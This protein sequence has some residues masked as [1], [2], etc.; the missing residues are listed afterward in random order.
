MD[1]EQQ[2]APDGAMRRGRIGTLQWFDFGASYR[3][4]GIPTSTRIA[5]VLPRDP[6][7]RSNIRF[8]TTVAFNR[9]VGAKE[10]DDV[11]E[12]CRWLLETEM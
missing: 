9:G 12:A 2:A 3:Q 8:V 4:A 7:K 6:V 10:F 11:D 5:H 1:S